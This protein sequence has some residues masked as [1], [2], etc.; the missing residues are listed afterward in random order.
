MLHALVRDG[1]LLSGGG[2]VL[3]QAQVLPKNRENRPF[4]FYRMWRICG[5][6]KVLSCHRLKI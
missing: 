1:V 3:G 2:R 5:N 6:R 4:I